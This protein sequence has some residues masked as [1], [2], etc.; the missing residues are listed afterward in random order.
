MVRDKRPSGAPPGRRAGRARSRPT[1]S[2][3][4]PGFALPLDGLGPRP[5]AAIVRCRRRR[6]PPAYVGAPVRPRPATSRRWVALFNAA[7]ADH[8]TP[9][10]LDPKFVAA[11][12]RRPGPATTATSILVE[13]VATGELVGFCA[14]DV[15]A[16][17][18]RVSPTTARSGSIGVRPDR[19]GRGLG[20]QLVRAGVER[21]AGDRRPERSRLSVN[22]RNESALGLYESEG[23]V[24]SRTRD[25]WARPRRL[26]T[27][28]EDQGA[29]LAP[30]PPAPPP[31]DLGPARPARRHRRAAA[32]G[33][34]ARRDVHLVLGD[35]LPLGAGLAR[36]RHVLPLLVR[37]AVAGRRSRTSSGGSSDRCRARRCGWR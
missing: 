6:G 1:R 36:D 33:G 3:R 37:A 23:F 34:A 28:R 9:L 11:G 12:T 26:V 35:L 31:D 16:A 19:Q 24:R 8:P 15:G 20:R 25:R 22:G 14:A 5:A 32:P 13:E 27:E 2:S 21:A 18:R 4:R 10:Q 17:R 7:F 30:T 29:T